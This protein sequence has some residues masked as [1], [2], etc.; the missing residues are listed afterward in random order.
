MGMK[1]G[2]EGQSDMLKKM[3]RDPNPKI[4]PEAIFR[5]WGYV[6]ASPYVGYTYNFVT[7]HG[8]NLKLSFPGNV[9]PLKGEDMKSNWKIPLCY[10]QNGVLGSRPPKGF[11]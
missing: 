7:N 11:F 10:F 6:G 2:G 3:G 5:Q 4:P 8:T 9:D 1:I